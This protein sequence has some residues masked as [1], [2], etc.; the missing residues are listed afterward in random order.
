MKNA[1][2]IHQYILDIENNYPVNDW[3]VNGVSIWPF[4][5][6]KLSADL[7]QVNNKNFAR[8]SQIFNNTDNKSKINRFIQSLKA[9]NKLKHS[10]YLFTSTYAHRAIY[11][12]EYWNKFYDPII[13]KAKLTSYTIVEHNTKLYY[14]DINKVKNNKNLYFFED[15]YYSTDVIYNKLKKIKLQNILK[16]KSLNKYDQLYDQLKH[17]GFL[18]EKIKNHQKENLLSQVERIFLLA[19]TYKKLLKKVKP[20]AI[21]EVCYYSANSLALNIASK[22]LNIPTVEFQHGPQPPIH[23]AYGNW[24]KINDQGY[25]MLPKIFWEWDEDSKKTVDNWLKKQKNHQS[26]LNGNP[27]LSFF[28]HTEN[29]YNSNQIFYSL[30]PFSNEKLFPPFLIAYIKQSSYKWILRVHPTD[31]NRI[32]EIENFL[33][34]SNVNNK[35]ELSGVNQPP[36]PFHLTNCFLHVTNYSGVAIEAAELNIKTIFIDSLANDYFSKLLELEK[37]Y[38]SDGNNFYELV[39][40]IKKQ[41]TTKK[42]ELKSPKQMFDDLL[43][44]LNKN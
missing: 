37:G 35:V 18:H 7:N 10:D 30:Q 41:N 26:I 44:L 22:G 31:F 20:K 2:E 8:K 34:L 42:K 14:S 38:F 3:K 17:D 16:K 43:T 5:R 1:K 4:I 40:Q 21:F 9:Y 29:D 28:K 33:K 11:N 25:K 19:K 23:S 32:K 13:E 24:R 12:E 6:I 15:F 39:E 36:L 27:W